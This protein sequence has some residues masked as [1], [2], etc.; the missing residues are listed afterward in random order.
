MSKK[1]LFNFSLKSELD[2]WAKFYIFYTATHQLIILKESSK[3][4]TIIIV[5]FQE[6]PGKMKLRK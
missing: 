5:M 3:G 4:K 6:F 2:M 1:K